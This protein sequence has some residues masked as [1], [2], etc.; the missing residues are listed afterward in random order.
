MAERGGNR[1]RMRFAPSPR[2]SAGQ[3]LSCL[4]TVRK[5]QLTFVMVMSKFINYKLQYVQINIRQN[6]ECTFVFLLL[7]TGIQAQSQAQ[8]K[9]NPQHYKCV[10]SSPQHICLLTLVL[11]FI[12]IIATC[13]DK[14]QVHSSLY[15]TVLSSRTVLMYNTCCC[16]EIA[17]F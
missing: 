2:L 4:C 5:L 8:L 15:V 1:P 12:R 11:V 3:L 14:L 10:S 6:T 9:Q 13:F 16:L 17:K 7:Y